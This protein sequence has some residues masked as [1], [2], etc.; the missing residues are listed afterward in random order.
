M[1][2]GPQSSDAEAAAR[3]HDRLA[4]AEEAVLEHARLSQRRASIVA[5]VEAAERD[6]ASQ[7]RVLTV[8]TGEL[9]ALEGISPTRIW[10]AL[11]G[12]RATE[13]ERERAEQQAQEYAVARAEARLATLRE[14][15]TRLERALQDLGDVRARRAVAL[16]AK[17]A[18]IVAS[19]AGP[20]AE[21]AEVA[22]ALGT[23]RAAAKE[24]H[25]ALVA[26]DLALQALSGAQS[27]LG[28][29]G[30]WSTY[31]TFFGGGL[32]TD[33]M[34]YDRVDTAERQMRS[35]DEALRRLSREL[36]DVGMDGVGGVEVTEMTRLF[37]V[38]FDNIFSDWSV[39]N[40]ISEAG[41]RVARAQGPVIEVRRVLVARAGELDAEIGRLEARRH[42]LLTDH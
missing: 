3:V 37:D 32:L 39:R 17:E 30:S 33:M 16:E 25:E 19:G 11:R 41:G 2:D 40:R 7:R 42:E 13:L 26:A 1:T 31:D 18:W 6:V 12:T 24:V 36:A 15:R 22:T 23:A 35:A 4:A 34:K 9:Q 10:H 20:A 5:E 14:E 8:Q 38:W 28:S 27:S 21:L 29:A